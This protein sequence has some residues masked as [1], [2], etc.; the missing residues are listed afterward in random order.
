MKLTGK[1]NFNTNVLR[2][3]STRVGSGRQDQLGAALVSNGGGWAG[4][5]IGLCGAAARHHSNRVLQSLPPASSP[6]SSIL[7]LWSR[8]I[9]RER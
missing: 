4:C 2:R 9:V 7:S 6:H 5:T 1:L 8:L 3:R